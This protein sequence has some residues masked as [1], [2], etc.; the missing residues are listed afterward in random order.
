MLNDEIEILRCQM[1]LKPKILCK[2]AGVGDEQIQEE[3][4]KDDPEKSMTDDSYQVV[5]RG[6]GFNKI[7]TSKIQALKNAIKTAQVTGLSVAWNKNSKRTHY[8]VGNAD[9]SS[10]HIEVDTD[11]LFQAA[12]LSKPVSAAIILDLVAQ[13][14]WDLDKP[15]AELFSYGS[16]ELKSNSYYSKLTTRMILAQSSGLPNW[17]NTDKAEDFI[18]EPGSNFTY[19]GVAYEFLKEAVEYNL[20]TSWETLT[21]AFFKKAGMKH[22]TFKQ[23]LAS[24]LKNKNLIVARGHDGKGIPDPFIISNDAKEVPAASLLTTAEDYLAFM[25]YCRKDSFLNLMMFT[26]HTALNTINFPDI[27]H[28]NSIHWGLGFGLYKN[29]NRNTIIFHWGNNPKSHAFTAMDL[30]SGD[31]VVCFTNSV[32]GP[33]IFKDITEAIVGEMGPVF[34][35]LSQYAQFNAE[36]KPTK[37][38]CL[39]VFF[40]DN[41]SKNPAKDERSPDIPLTIKS[42][43]S[44]S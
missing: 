8:A 2:C 31:S 14:R 9:A 35:W 42:S 3:H 32:N 4:E 26:P 23:P 5:F 27:D 41:L 6:L 29:L 24:H 33:N 37:A 20:G 43:P 22:S 34:N 13:G 38:N 40:K 1:C 18:A 16:A 30:S 12:S 7:D 39:S 15:L 19:S 21:Q 17:F 25:N 11:T 44:S 28:V 36:A 10:P